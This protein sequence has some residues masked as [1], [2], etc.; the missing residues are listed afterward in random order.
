MR[1]SLYLPIT[2]PP[3]NKKNVS[4]TTNLEA[5][6]SLSLC[7]LWKDR[8]LFFLDTTTDIEEVVV[9]GEIRIRF[10][11]EELLDVC[12]SKHTVLLGA[13]P[14]YPWDYFVLFEQ[15]DCRQL[16]ICVIQLWVLLGDHKKCRVAPA[17]SRTGIAD[18]DVRGR[19]FSGWETDKP[20][21]SIL[22]W[23]VFFTLNDMLK[24]LL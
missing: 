16:T 10:V 2:I 3:D 5:A 18:G 19:G 21:S 14:I 17:V 8:Y 20:L 24:V 4:R 7:I 11:W 12:F 22:L 6:E 13:R 23:L 15:L 9:N 1:Q